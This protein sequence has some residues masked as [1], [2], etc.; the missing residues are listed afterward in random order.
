MKKL[1]VLLVVMCACGPDASTP[2]DAGVDGHPDAMVDA[3]ID[4]P[5]QCVGLDDGIDCTVDTCDM[6]TGQV[7]HTPT[8][9]MCNDDVACTTDTCDATTGCVYTPDATACDDG[10]DC[11]VDACD[12]TNGCSH[13]T[14]DSLCETDGAS[15]TVAQCDAV[16]GCSEVPTN[17]ICDDGA[18]CSTDTCDPTATGADAATGC[19]YDLDNNACADTA[20]CSTDAC[21]PGTAGA[22]AT[23]GCLYTADP[24]A[25][26]ANATC[27]SG[28]DCTCNTG[29]MGDGLT[30]AAVVCDALTAP[31]NG[32][33]SVAN[34]GVYPSTATYTCDAGYSISP[35][36]TRTCGT[37]GHWSGS[38]PTCVPTTVFVLRVGD[39]AASLSNAATALFVEER[40]A[41][42]GSL[43]RTITIPATG[44]GALTQSGT[45][46]SEGWIN[47]S[48][49]GRYVVFPGYAADAG[50]ASIANT[51]NLSTDAT[52]VNRGIGRID[53]T[54][55]VDTSTRFVDVFSGGNPR[56][57]A[58]VDGT[59]FWVAGTG[60]GATSG[61][62]Y[63]TL[64]S[65]GIAERLD[66]GSMTDVLIAEGQLYEASTSA[67]NAVGTGLPAS[68]LQTDTTIATVSSVRSFAFLDT[69]AT[70]GVDTLYLAVDSTSGTAGVINVQ[71]FTLDTTTSTWTKDAAFAPQLAGVSGGGSGV[72][73]LTAW[74]DGGQVHV[75]ATLAVTNA[76]RLVSFI[77]DSETP[78]VNVLATAAANTV[79]RGVALS[80][81]VAP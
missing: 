49:D 19:V 41:T 34:G 60:S 37:D 35:S 38:D 25:C 48:V 29:F 28:F 58:T 71:K 69:D 56:G 64:G 80:P 70:A 4:A 73:G 67:V 46:T 21:S 22:D 31:A 52:P 59:R 6:A 77:D 3:P 65:T 76:N 61:T 43:V 75:I 55:A 14:M 10:V 44:A 17:A 33:V 66:T 36:A 74:L 47:R 13:T 79:F 2:Q 39:G 15:C 50:T 5:P 27:S 53:E 23:S 62:F 9:T 42:D 24:T 57:V 1:A 68:G 45:A 30:C 51:T 72:R 26:D 40:S 54:G 32:S 7:T 12:A 63:V 81:T 18:T 20:E 11:T 16:A 8:N 78:A